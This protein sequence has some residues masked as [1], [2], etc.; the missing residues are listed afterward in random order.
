MK[1]LKTRKRNNRFCNDVFSTLERCRFIKLLL[2]CS[3][4]ENANEIAFPYQKY[5]RLFKLNT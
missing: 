1:M 2:C 5:T 3:T 4:T